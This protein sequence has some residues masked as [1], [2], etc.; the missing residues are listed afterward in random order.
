MGIY[1]ASK[2]AVEAM[3]DAMRVELRGSGVAVSLVEPG[4]IK[5]RFGVN[6][7]VKGQETLDENAPVYGARYRNHLA[8]DASAQE[9]KKPEP[10]TLPPEAVAAKIAHAL[11]ASR[12]RIRYPVTI[13]AHIGAWMRRLAPDA[14]VDYLMWF[15]TSRR[16]NDSSR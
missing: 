8:A 14:F 2:Y 13:P 1:S 11:E 10:F 16:Y 4:P 12:P 7:V 6:S 3:A 15:R 9:N 5:T